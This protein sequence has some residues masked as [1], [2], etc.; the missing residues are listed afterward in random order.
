M[1][2]QKKEELLEIVKKVKEYKA[3]LCDKFVRARNPYELRYFVVG[4]HDDRIQQYKQLLVEMDA[5]YKALE[6]AQY[7][8]SLADIDREEKELERKKITSMGLSRKDILHNKRIDI[9][10]AH[11]DLQAK[12]TELAM[13]GALK[14]CINF[15]EMI[16][17]EYSDLKVLSEEDALLFEKNYWQDR[18]SRQI[19]IDMITSGRIGAG[20]LSVLSNMPKEDQETILIK[21][22][23]KTE[24]FKLLDAT[25]SNEAKKLLNASVPPKTTFLASPQEQTILLRKDAPLEYPEHLKVNL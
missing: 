17:N 13:L 16:D 21:A 5:K 2:Y 1:Q 22:I 12:D 8:L 24:E 19:E 23:Q 20:N 3:E 11:M 4:K 25:A 15:T 6:E 18:L 10:L 9:E 7:K 14:E